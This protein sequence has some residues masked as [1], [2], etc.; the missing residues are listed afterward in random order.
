MQ[1]VQVGTLKHELVSI[2][3]MVKNG[4]EF[5]VEFGRKYEPVAVIIPYS[6]YTKNKTREFGLLQNKASFEI[7]KDFEISDEEFLG[8]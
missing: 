7:K 6:E 5:I 1:T 2:L 8:L 3:D 4:Q